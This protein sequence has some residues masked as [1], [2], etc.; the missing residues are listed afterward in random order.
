MVNDRRCYSTPG[1]F[2]HFKSKPMKHI[3]TVLFILLASLYTLKASQLEKFLWA[4][5][6]VY[7]DSPS[8]FIAA[9]ELVESNHDV[10]LVS[11]VM[12]IGGMMVEGLGNQDIDS[13]S[14][15]GAPIG[16]LAA[17]FYLRI[18]RAYLP[19]TNTP[20][21]SFEAK[22]AQ[23]VINTWLAE[24][25]V[26]QLRGKRISEA[27]GA[28]TKENAR[29]TSFLLEDGTRIA[30]RIF[31]D[32]TVEGDL[33]AFANVSYAWG[34]EGNAK[35][36]ENFGGV[37][38]PSIKDQYNV[39]VDPY[40]IPG[41]PASGVLTG[42]QNQTIGVNG[43]ADGSAMGFCFRLP[44]TKNPANKIP[45]TAPANYSASTYE[46]YRRFLAAGGMNDWLD[47]PG[48]INSSTTTK[49]FDLGSWHNLSG[50][51]YG[52]NHAY[53]NGSYAVREQIYQE[54]QNFTQGLIYFLSTD[55]N[56]PAAVRNEW[57]RWGLC[58]DEFTDNG[59]WP[60]RL[61]VRCGRRMIS[62]Y[63]ITEKDVRET[64]IGTVTP[65]PAVSDPI[66]LAYWPV[67]LHSAHTLIRNG[68]V[69]NEGAYFDLTNYKKSFGIPYR[70][71][72][73]KRVDCTNLLV[74]SALSS[75]YAGYGAVR[76]EWTFMVLGQSAAVAAA[77]A[78]DQQ[79]AVQDVP[80]ASLR[81]L[82]LARNQRLSLPGNN[83]PT[84]GAE[85]IVDN[86][87]ATGV[88]LSGSWTISTTIPGHYGINYLHDGNSGK[89][90][91]TIRFTPNL[92]RAGNY[93]VYTRWS[94]GGARAN[95]VPMQITS[96][97]GTTSITVNQQLNG[98]TWVLLGTWAFA[99]GNPGSLLI[100]NTGTIGFVIA[101]A[102][103][104]VEIISP[105][106]Q[107]QIFVAPLNGLAIE[108][109]PKPA[110]IVIQRN[111][112]VSNAL[113]VN[114]A[115]AGTATPSSD[116]SPLPTSIT[117]AA[118]IS[119]MVLDVVPNQDLVVE[120]SETVVI[121]VSPG[122]TYLSGDPSTAVVTIADP[123]Y[124]LWRRSEFDETDLQTP[125]VSEPANDPDGD[126]LPNLLEHVLQG[127]PKQSDSASRLPQLSRSPAGE[128]P[129]VDLTFWRKR[130]TG[131]SVVYPIT[132]PN[133]LEWS[134]LTSNGE[135]FAYNSMEDSIQ[136]RYRIP[137]VP[138]TPRFFVRLSAKP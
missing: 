85:V 66:G 31:I 88:T 58:A 10:L 55:P 125:N 78:L 87:D 57:S 14:G 36:G 49:L 15:N 117:F 111:G 60:R 84:T 13:R 129:F 50:N 59:G 112:N 93:A 21:Y 9:I 81:T 97:G 25:G 61:Y 65:A 76:L 113:S 121:S 28:V 12:N 3:S 69:H 47:G 22:V 24:K 99:G 44:L 73:P 38:N 6:V 133:L 98:N 26:R 134:E 5:V 71:I 120:G 41:N 54:H 132:S 137:I 34:R 110:K 56:V 123:S 18:A 91:K 124:D 19:G 136:V 43:A 128:S 104:F 68:F 80:Y 130:E 89:N 8:A 114:L 96:A 102:A 52:R 79:V 30:G 75:S 92:P 63:V 2:G 109:N 4:D 53:P 72:I 127:D 77:M 27:P 107:S 119:S 100:E 74:P 138:G 83:S 82:L 67:D 23:T 86:S 101:D 105:P 33:M 17:E 126:D 16:G 51:L 11:P 37:V 94:A 35:Y 40:V 39:N 32:G 131:D 103:R 106:D 108:S 116:Y 122:S 1:S 95:S 90:T 29:I 62:D 48:A 20:R 45:I 70:S 42:V 64:P 46:L 135:V 118:G 115:I 7:G